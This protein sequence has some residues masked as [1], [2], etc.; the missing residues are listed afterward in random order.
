[1]LPSLVKLLEATT[2]SNYSDFPGFN[3]K[4]DYNPY[5]V[6]IDGDGCES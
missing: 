6:R 4:G 2:S 3:T 1:M 5:N